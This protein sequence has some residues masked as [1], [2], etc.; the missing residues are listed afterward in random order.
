VLMTARI[1]QFLH[2]VLPAVARPLRI[3]W[4]QIIGFLF[5]V[6]ALIAVPRLYRALQEFDG[7]LRSSFEVALSGIFVLVM[8]GFGIS[9]FWRAHKISRSA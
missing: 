4:N 6:L 8:G 9:S 3:L 7:D 1:R 5:L 2:Y